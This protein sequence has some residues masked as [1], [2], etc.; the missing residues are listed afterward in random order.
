MQ[1]R[2]VVYRDGKLD[3]C[4]PVAGARIGYR[5]GPGQPRAVAVARGLQAARVPGSGPPRDGP[6]ATWAAERPVVNGKRVRENE[7]A[8]WRQT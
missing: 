5:T 7:R 8:G 1:A 3:L 2:L 4:V 6:S